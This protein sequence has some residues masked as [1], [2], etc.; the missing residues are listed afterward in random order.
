M[1]DEW[2]KRLKAAYDAGYYK[3]E[4]CEEQQVSFPWQT[5]ISKA[6]FITRLLSA[7]LR[8]PCIHWRSDLVWCSQCGRLFSTMT[9]G[10]RKMHRVWCWECY[11]VNVLRT[12]TMMA[13]GGNAPP[14][15]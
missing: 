14:S 13:A 3:T 8:R 7:L 15:G 2:I 10:A 6:S 4:A 11:R 5:P 1:P 12:P 9:R